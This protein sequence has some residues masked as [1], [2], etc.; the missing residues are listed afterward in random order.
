LISLAEVDRAEA[1]LRARLDGD[2]ASDPAALLELK[3]L[4]WLGA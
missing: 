4:R 1:S 3:D 2:P